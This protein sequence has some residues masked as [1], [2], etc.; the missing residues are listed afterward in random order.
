MAARFAQVEILIVQDLFDSPLWRRATY[1]LPGG[2]YAERS[3]SYVN[4]Q[5]RL[6]FFKWAVRPPAGAKVEGHL[7]WQMLGMRGLYN[8]RQVLNEIAAAI[9]YFAVA[10]D[11]VPPT[12]VDLKINQLA[13]AT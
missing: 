5:D 4:Y 1:Q 7:Y 9:P 10:M 12:G 2:G 6:Q 3:G 13:S 8:A 11:L